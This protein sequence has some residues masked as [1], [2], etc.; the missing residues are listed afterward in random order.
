ML[1]VAIL[2]LTLCVNASLAC[3]TQCYCTDTQ[4]SCEKI[5]LKEEDLSSLE[6]PE[7]IKSMKLT[8]NELT[9]I[10]EGSMMN[11]RNLEE[12][13]ISKNKIRFIPIFTFRGFTKLRKLIL[14][15]NEITKLSEGSFI[16]LDN[17]QELKIEHNKITYLQGGVF[18]RLKSIV[19]IRLN[20]NLIGSIQNNVFTPLKTLR[21]LFLT[22]NKIEKIDD[23]AFKDMKMNRLGLSNNRIEVIP[24]SAFE[25]LFIG[26]KILFLNNPLDC[27]C[28]HAM[29]YKVNFNHLKNKVWGYCSYPQTALTHIFKAHE[30][31]MSCT[32][33]D[34]EPCKNGGVC[35][36][37]KETFKCACP[38]RF[39]GDTCDENICSGYTGPSAKQEKIHLKQINH[40]EYVIVKE[41]IDNEDDAKKLKI[42][43]AMCSFEFIVIICFVVYFMWKRYEEWKLQ[44][45]YEHEKSRAILFSIRNQTNAQLAKALVEENEDFPED[46][47]NMILKGSV[48]V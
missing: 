35:T 9:G 29:S 43:Y 32:L 13:E 22:R 44:K 1:K 17:L 4:M 18:D 23:H 12:L 42:L 37:N 45:Q 7:G 34:L 36:G 39:K 26:D 21:H 11:F 5:D 24:P 16:G 15:E 6:V 10:S 3:P 28:K 47:K 27:S 46:L 25:G 20:D 33:C 40:T 31:M 38:E 8:S 48:P 30:D 41:R 19:S 2:L 14:N